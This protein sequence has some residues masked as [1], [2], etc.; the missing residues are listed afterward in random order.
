MSAQIGYAFQMMTGDMRSK[1]GM[2]MTS[3]EHRYGDPAVYAAQREEMAAEQA[4]V[5]H[6]EVKSH[7][8]ALAV[9]YNKNRDRIRETHKSR[10][11]QF[12][13][14][15]PPRYLEADQEAPTGRNQ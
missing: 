2:Y 15:K 12:A 3:L 14:D 4:M 11:A 6:S 8:D 7:E 13:R 1:L 10:M 5:A 9:T